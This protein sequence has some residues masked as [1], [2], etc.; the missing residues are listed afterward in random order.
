LANDLAGKLIYRAS[1]NPSAIAIAL[2]FAENAFDKAARESSKWPFVA[3][4]YSSFA[5]GRQDVAM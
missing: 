3:S 1:V 2:T 4:A 5:V